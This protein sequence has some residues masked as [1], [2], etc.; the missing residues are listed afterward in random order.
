MAG[1][2]ALPL[3]G[4]L[5]K[6]PGSAD[7][8][9]GDQPEVLPRARCRR[10]PDRAFH[11]HRQHRVEG[12]G[13]IAKGYERVIRPRFADAVLL[14][15]RPEAGP[16]L[17]ERGPKTVTCRPLGSYA[18]KV[19]ASPHWPKRL[20]VRSASIRRRRAA[21]GS[22]ARPTCQSRMVNE[23][24]ELQGIAGRYYPPPKAS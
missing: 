6:V 19:R 23:F 12:T 7:L 22:C 14:R 20:R 21:P 17:D 15:R 24:P 5:L 18:D 16:R 10:S 4:N 13:E 3:R 11:R 9:H 1:G 8:H 2:G